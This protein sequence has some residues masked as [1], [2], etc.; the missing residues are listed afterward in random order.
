[1]WFC[2]VR[3]GNLG[4]KVNITADEG[5]PFLS[6]DGSELW[7]CGHSRLGYA[8]PSVFRSLR[9]VDGSWGEPEEIIS[10]FAGEPTLDDAG[11]IYYTHHFFSQ[12]G[13]ML[14]ADIYVA[15]RK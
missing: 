3:R 2:S 14:E 15:Y 7:F 5:W 6:S 1:M 13:V 12:N 8:G 10:N 11:N 9:A 4:A